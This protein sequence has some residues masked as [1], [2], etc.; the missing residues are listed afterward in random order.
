MKKCLKFV[1]VSFWLIITLNP[2]HSQVKQSHTIAVGFLQLK[3]QFNFGM[4]FNG[5]QLEYRY[6]LR[7]N[8]NDHE[9]LYQ[10][11]LNFGIGFN[12]GIMGFQMKLAPINVTWTMPFY[13]QNGH[14]IRGGAN[15]TADYSYQVY[16]DLHIGHLFWA[17]EIGISPVVQY[18]YQWENRRIGVNVQNSLLGFTSHTQEVEPYWFSLKARE[19]FVTPHENMKFG[20]FDKYNHT[21][22]SFEFVPNIEKK[23]SWLYEFDYFGSYYGAEFSRLNHN[24][25]WRMAL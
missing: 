11:K 10:P 15:L 4:I 13:K 25:I 3:D 1:F 5:V 18:S 22:V 2:L 14:T 19:W 7:W 17:S 6:G 8:I 24:L 12:R 20:S 23:H 21:T 16:P 9:I